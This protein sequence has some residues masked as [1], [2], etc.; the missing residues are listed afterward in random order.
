MRITLGGLHG[1]GGKKCNFLFDTSVAVVDMKIVLSGNQNRLR[2]PLI[3]QTH[4]VRGAQGALVP[5][6]FRHMTQADGSAVMSLKDPG[7]RHPASPKDYPAT[8]GGI[9]IAKEF[10]GGDEAFD[11]GA[12]PLLFEDAQ[13]P[14]DEVEEEAGDHSV[15]EL[16]ESS[17]VELADAIASEEEYADHVDI[18][19]YGEG[20]EVELESPKDVDD[21]YSRSTNMN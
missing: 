21:L 8:S 17:Q 1:P 12:D 10:D 7:F 9:G 4:L 19:T 11:S 2:V 18:Y 6:T 16:D 3:V 14:L 13:A 5:Y 15:G 20:E